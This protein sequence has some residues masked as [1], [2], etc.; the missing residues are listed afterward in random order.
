MGI[1]VG[2][3][4]SKMIPLH[5]LTCKTT[6]IKFVEVNYEVSI[7]DSFRAMCSFRMVVDIYN[8]V[9]RSLVPSCHVN[10]LQLYTHFE[11]P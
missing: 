10:H 3:C 7:V 5:E 11:T 6:F 2:L 9:V 4:W 1:C 8:S